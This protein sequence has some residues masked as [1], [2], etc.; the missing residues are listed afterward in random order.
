MRAVTL[1][2]VLGSKKEDIFEDCR[3]QVQV[4]GKNDKFRIVA[5]INMKSGER[6]YY[7]AKSVDHTSAVRETLTFIAALE[8]GTGENVLWRF[9]GEKN[10]TFSTNYNGK[11]SVLQQAK[12]AFFRYFFELE[13]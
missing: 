13:A 1:A 10:F 3:K 8:E 7:R 2:E 9:K 11:P 5:E 12:S 6:R 4:L